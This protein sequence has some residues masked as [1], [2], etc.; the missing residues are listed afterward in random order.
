MFTLRI[1][2]PVPRA[3]AA[4]TR[5]A[6]QPLPSLATT[7]VPQAGYDVTG[8][9]D[10]DFGKEEVGAAKTGADGKV[11]FQTTGSKKGKVRVSFCVDSVSGTPAYYK[12]DNVDPDFDCN[13]HSIGPSC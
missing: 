9:F 10:G 4:V 13:P 2:K 12:D 5:W 6:P 3:L 1:S 8:T 11:T 7:G